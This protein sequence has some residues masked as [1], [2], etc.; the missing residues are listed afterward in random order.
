MKHVSETELIKLVADELEP[1]RRRLIEQHLADCAQCRESW[2]RQQAVW[3]AL[4]AWDEA[5]E[6]RDLWQQI[7]TRLG[8]PSGGT[9]QPRILRLSRAARLAAAVALGVGLGYGAGRMAAQQPP[10]TASVEEAASEALGLGVLAEDSPA[11]L[12]DALVGLTE[13]QGGES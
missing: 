6:Q 1:E 13:A 8:R 5:T 3:E 10:P 7:E 12:F 11:G 2:R 9:G 4:G